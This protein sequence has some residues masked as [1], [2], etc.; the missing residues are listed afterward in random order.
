VTMTVSRPNSLLSENEIVK[1]QRNN[2]WTL[3]PADCRTPRRKCDARIVIAPLF[4]EVR[5]VVRILKGDH[6]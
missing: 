6:K 5:R 3:D 1:T 4:R 2:L